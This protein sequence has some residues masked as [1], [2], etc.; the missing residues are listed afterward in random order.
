MEDPHFKQRH[1]FDQFISDGEAL[2]SALPLP[3]AKNLSDSTSKMP[4]PH[5]GEH[6]DEFI[7]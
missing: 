6:N 5:L 1:V 4:Y 7:K 3:L 2:L